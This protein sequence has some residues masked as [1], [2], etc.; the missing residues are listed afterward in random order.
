M[1]FSD[2]AN[3]IMDAAFIPADVLL[4]AILLYSEC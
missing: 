3:A 2:A 1:K 4:L